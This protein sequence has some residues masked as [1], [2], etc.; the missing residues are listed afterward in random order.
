[1]QT[2]S[3]FGSAPPNCLKLV[4]R[5]ALYKHGM[6]LRMREKNVNLQHL[7]HLWC[8]FLLTKQKSVDPFSTPI[9]QKQLLVE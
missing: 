4:M 6:L 5:M 7:L 8:N 1:M 3:K 9:A 2:G